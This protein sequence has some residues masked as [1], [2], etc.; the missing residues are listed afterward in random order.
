MHFVLS[1]QY[2][3][4]YRVN[5]PRMIRLNVPTMSITVGD[6]CT[7]PPVGLQRDNITY[8][9]SRL[10]RVDSHFVVQKL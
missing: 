8:Y 3:K 9:I 1:F 5:M 7:A 2:I 4:F 6:S 10:G